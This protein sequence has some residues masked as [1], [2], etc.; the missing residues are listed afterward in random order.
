MKR[1]YFKLMVVIALLCTLFLSA[2]E[3]STGEEE[4][5]E[6]PQVIIITATPNAQAPVVTEPPAVVPTEPPAL[7]TE[8]PV[9]P[10]EPPVLPT[11]P[12]VEPTQPPAETEA[13]EGGEQF[14]RDEFDNGLDQYDRFISQKMTIKSTATMSRWKRKPVLN[15]VT[16]RL[17]STSRITTSI[18]ILFINLRFTKM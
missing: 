3:F 13:P 11:E 4:T 1:N 18:I 16:G 17:N 5:S 10:T 2:C 14:F 9:L 15:S 6:A 12:P 8:P 7:P